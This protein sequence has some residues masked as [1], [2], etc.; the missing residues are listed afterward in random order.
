M[1]VCVCVYVKRCLAICVVK[2]EHDKI[3]SAGVFLT[4]WTTDIEIQKQKP[5][6]YN[7]DLWQEA[8]SKLILCD[9]L[10]R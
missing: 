3:L 4:L 6:R 9:R 10:S 5:Q 7:P 2:V 8:Q 1:C